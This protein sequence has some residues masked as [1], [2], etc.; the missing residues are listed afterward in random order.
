MSKLS[1]ILNKTDDE[2]FN[3]IVS[4]FKDKITTWDYFVDWQKVLANIEKIETELNILNT[5][6]GKTDIRNKC[7][8]LCFRY[9]EVIKILPSLLA[10]RDYSLDV[11]VDIQ[12][13]EYKSFDFNKPVYSLEEIEQ[14]T[15]FFMDSGLGQL[16][17]DKRIKNLVD[18][19]TGVEVGLD[20]NARKNRG[21][22]LME[23]ITE[24]FIQ[25]VCNELQLD[26]MAQATAKKIKQAWNINIKVD[27]SSR[28][29]DFAINKG[30][31]LFFIEVNF[32]GGGGSKLKSTAGEYIEMHR[33]WTQQGIEFIWITDGAGWRN[34]LNPLR[35]YFDKTDYLL[36]LELL[37]EK[38]LNKI[39][40]FND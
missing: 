22:K 8:D 20:S 1:K 6:I 16:F 9:P 37:K 4:T 39:L 27:K 7:I 25:E 28:R 18:Y 15:D 30:G 33:F 2:I 38:I 36:N 34:T 19:V 10:L 24:K 21:G 5:L 17:N 40:I 29:I 35:E 32:Y 14:L 12:N 3:F 13:F 26:Y 31:K 11:L 23:K